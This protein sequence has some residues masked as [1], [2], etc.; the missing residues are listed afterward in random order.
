MKSFR[1]YLMRVLSFLSPLALIACGDREQI[2]LPPPPAETVIA[3]V[4][5]P[6]PCEITH[7]DQPDYPANRARSSDDIFTLA[8]IAAADRRV[9]IGET[10]KL[11]P[12]N[13][14]PCPGDKK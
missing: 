9:R 1:Y 12:A 2:T 4:A 3:K 11:R 7:V 6:V 14:T 13:Q 10:E 5:V 8:K